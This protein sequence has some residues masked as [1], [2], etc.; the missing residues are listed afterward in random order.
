MRRV[1][2]AICT[3][4]LVSGLA[5]AQ[6]SDT[7]SGPCAVTGY[8]ISPYTQVNADF[9]VRLVNDSNV[10]VATLMS[11]TQE[12][13]SFRGLARGVYYVEAD[14]GGF[15]EIRQRVDV[16]GVEREGQVS[17]ML[18]SQSQ[19]AFNKP[20]D[21]MD[22][23]D[24]VVN[25]ADL[26]RSP[27]VMK[28]FQEATRKLQ[29][30]D[31]NG[32]RARLESLVSAA[33]DFYDA[34]KSLGT[35]Y[36]QIRRYEDAEKE[37]NLARSLRPNSAVPLM[38]LGSL[39]LE[40]VELGGES[41]TPQNDVL[42]KARRALLRAI[43]VNPSVAF[44]RY[45]LGVT[46]YKL[47]LYKDSESSL[48]RALQ[49]DPKLGDIR[50]ALANVYVRVQDWVKALDQLDSYLRENPKAVDRNRVVEM[51]ARVE[52]VKGEPRVP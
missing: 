11:R 48:V 10:V 8:I 34:H 4:F 35:A 5:N 36:Q 13:F 29:N 15:K 50:L 27:Q 17:I 44:A 41:K 14:I 23:Q 24:D 18:E 51:R 7:R 25:V 2:A 20:S 30:G 37:Y 45:L 31:V 40:R 47:G 6:F 52:R 9:E 49:M 1:A 32:A 22:E 21:P 33:P 38:L 28:K 43:E 19:A 39:Y 26:N 16:S 3:L 12:H 42:E 46:Y